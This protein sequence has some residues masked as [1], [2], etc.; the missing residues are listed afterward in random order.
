[1]EKFFPFTD[2]PGSSV[3]AL[4]EIRLIERIRAAFEN[5]SP[6]PPRGIGDDCAVLP[7]IPEN[8]PSV[9]AGTPKRIVTTDSLI[10][11]KHFD[12]TVS[13]ED[14]GKKLVRRNVSDIAAT[15]G[16][17]ADAVLALV[18]SGNVS[19]AWFDRFLNGI[20][21]ACAECG[22]ELSGGDIASA[23]VSPLFSATLALTGFTENP[24]LRSG[25]GEGDF[26]FVTGT[27]GG[28][29]LKKHYA[30]RPRIAEGRFL[31]AL[32]A[33]TV[34]ACIDVTDGLLKD[35][36]ALL[37]AGTH[38]EFDFSALPISD[39]AL[40][41]GGDVIRRVFCDGEDYELL[42]AVAETQ[43]NDFEKIWR[44]RFP[45]T[46]ISRIAEIVSGTENPALLHRLREARA[47]EHFRSGL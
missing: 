12:E 47:Y 9:V 38:A 28:S 33:G 19:V 18:M 24:L 37:P 4:G 27:L 46:R 16:V 20:A 13:P 2:E 45:E 43:A 21:A 41:L 31:A 3:G 25:A 5:I 11:S 10:F 17:P 8:F 30:F 22:T 42:I 39:D 32:P 34:R 14:A 7:A 44:E 29:I 23:P 15:G 40:A 26:L 36:A 1:M 35:H 6:P